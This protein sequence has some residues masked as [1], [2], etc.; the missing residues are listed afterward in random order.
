MNGVNY[1]HRN[2]G[3]DVLVYCTVFQEVSVMGDRLYNKHTFSM[4]ITSNHGSKSDFKIILVQL[5]AELSPCHPNFY[6]D[7]KTCVCYNDSDVMSCSGSTSCIKRGY[8]FGDVDNIA[9]VSVYQNSYCN[10]VVVKKLMDFISF[11]QTEQVNAIHK[12]Q[13]LLVVAVKRDILFYRM[14]KS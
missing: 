10:F 7:K 8:W 6:H 4:N 3:S 11:H 9:T 14:C 2:N 1:H 5:I 12:D 13:V